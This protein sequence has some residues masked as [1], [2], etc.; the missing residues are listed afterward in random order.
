VDDTRVIKFRSGRF[1]RAWV[2]NV[3]AVGNSSGF[4]EPLESTAL[5][6]IC[7]QV[8][9]LAEGLHECDRELRQSIRDLYNRRN[10]QSWDQ[11]RKFLSIHFKFNQRYETEYW[12]SCRED[13]DIQ[14]AADVVAYYREIGPSVFWRK[15]LL[16]TNDQFGT[17]GYLSL[18]VGQQVEYESSH[19]PSAADWDNWKRIQEAIK[20]KATA[21][22][23]VREG[24]AA[25]RA[26]SWRWPADLY[27]AAVP[28]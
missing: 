23:T 28:S 21:A 27:K 7:G 12:R 15:V 16:D 17:E 10:A 19:T 3:V 2:K 24:L 6:A 20:R 22:L 9:V 8:N 26:P 11:I 4:V 13:A 5:A 18:L 14:S 1:E 25:I